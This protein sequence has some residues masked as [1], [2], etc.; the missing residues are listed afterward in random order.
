MFVGRV[1]LIVI[2]ILFFYSTADGAGKISDEKFVVIDS[3][4][5]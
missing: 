5:V 1:L 3:K 4:Y 2:T